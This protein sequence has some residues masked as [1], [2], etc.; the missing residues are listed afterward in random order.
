MVLVA[1]LLAYLLAFLNVVN[2]KNFL[3]FEESSGLSSEW[4]I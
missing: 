1:L 2:G 3:N 4:K